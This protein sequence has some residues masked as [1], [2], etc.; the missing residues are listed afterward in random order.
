MDFDRV[1][2]YSKILYRTVIHTYLH[3]LV[4][5]TIIMARQLA[6]IH[7]TEEDRVNCPFYFKVG[8]CRHEDRC[9]R[10]HLKPAFSQTILFKHLYKRKASSIPSVTQE[11]LL[12]F[13]ED[14]YMELS[15]FGHIV[16]LHVLENLGDH[17][18]GHVY[19][20]FRDE[21]EAANALEALS[22]RYYDGVLMNIEYSPVTDFTE[23]RCRDFDEE[24]CQRQG[25]CNFLHVHPM[26]FCLLKSL[27]EDADEVRREKRRELKKRKREK[28]EHK[29]S[30]RSREDD[31]LSSGEGGGER[32][33]DRDGDRDR[34]RGRERSRERRSR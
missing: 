14:L 33:R 1:L 12:C 21:E 3:P 22:G 9:S 10:R 13:F 8:A 32:D 26:P 29:R 19:C 11:H 17:M 4:V 23:A 30:K 5:E 31:S 6:R 34:D 25:F 27:E 16:G 20:K 18:L 7:G 15:V 2:L 28:K 24:T